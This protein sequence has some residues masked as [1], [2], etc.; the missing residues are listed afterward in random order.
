MTEPAVQR[1][2]LPPPRGPIRA[3]LVNAWRTTVL[4]LAWNLLK[5]LIWIR[6]HTQ[7]KRWFG[8]NRREVAVRLW[9]VAWLAGVWVL[10]WGTYDLANVLV[11]IGVALV[12]LIVLPLPRVPVEGR[13]HPL[14]LLELCVRLL[15]D[16]CKSSVQVAWLAIRPAKPPLSAVLRV[17]M[18]IKSD[19]VLT[20]A[21]DYLNLVPGTMVLEID[22]SRRL[23]YVH[24][25]DASSPEKVKTFHKQV[26][27]TERMFIRAFER[28]SEWHASPYHGIDDDYPSGVMK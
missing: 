25:I 10:L 19:M 2:Q 24:L 8:G 20:L 4:Y 27:T 7:I 13:V 21:V 12:V 16:L 23:L 14:T 26:A 1:P 9:T 22:H 17:R 3:H 6:T 5:I 11:G 28:D 15:I 18:A